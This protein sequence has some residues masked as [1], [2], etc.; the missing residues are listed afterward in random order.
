MANWS[1]KEEGGS[2][3][4]TFVVRDRERGRV[5]VESV[6]IKVVTSFSPSQGG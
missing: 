4:S 2:Q 5:W 6:Q 1:R 3:H